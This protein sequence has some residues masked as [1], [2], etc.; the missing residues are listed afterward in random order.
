MK[1]SFVLPLSCLCLAASAARA[2][3]TS[4]ETPK[5]QQS[6]PERVVVTASPLDRSAFD[7]AQ[8]VSQLSGVAL[9]SKAATTLGDALD[10]EPGISQSGFTSG[11]SRPIIRGQADNRV[12][13][14]NDGT[15]VFDVSEPLAR[16]RAEHR[17]AA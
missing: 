7:L 2:Q 4:T 9:K 13:V 15:E 17:T 10:G 8:P 5:T 11:A 6:N 1:F 3:D 16:P 14:L 12:R